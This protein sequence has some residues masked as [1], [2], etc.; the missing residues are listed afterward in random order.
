[1]KTS[2]LPGSWE[3]ANNGLRTWAI[4]AIGST[5]ATIR[6]GDTRLH[7]LACMFFLLVISAAP[8]KIMLRPHAC[9]N[10]MLQPHVRSDHPVDRVACVTCPHVAGTGPYARTLKA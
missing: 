8:G 3:S 10:H 1:G 6:N 2:T 7:V 4:A 9:A 5:S